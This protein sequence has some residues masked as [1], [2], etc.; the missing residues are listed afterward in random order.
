[1]SGPEHIGGDTHSPAPVDDTPPDPNQLTDES[2]QDIR[3]AAVLN[4][5][6]SLAV[7]MSGIT[8]ELHHL[9]LSSRGVDKWA[10]YGQVL[11]LL[12]GTVRIDVIAGT[13]AG[14]LNG[15]FLALG[16]TRQ[17]DLMLLRDLWRDS[18]ALEDLLR[19][20]LVKSPPSLLDGD[21]YF[22]PQIRQALK[23]IRD[24]PQ[25]LDEPSDDP[26]ELILTG[27]LWT[28]RETTFTDDMGVGITERDHDA[29]FRF[30][31]K[32][33]S[34]GASVC[35]DLRSDDVLDRLAEAARCTS[36]FPGAFEP[37]KVSVATEYGA[38]SGQR[39]ASSAG[40]SNFDT[41]QYVVDGGV[42]L[43]K[44][45]RPALGAIH[46]QTAD[47][48]VRRIL[49]YIVPDP[50]EAPK[51]ATGVSPATDSVPVASE[52]LLGVVTR[53]QATDS[54]SR[55][56]QE[57]RDRNTATRARRR[58]RSAL[59][60]AMMETPELAKALWPFYRA[61]RLR[62]AAITIGRLIAA[63]QPAGAGRWS[64]HEITAALTRHSAQLQQDYS[65]APPED[66]SVALS[67]TGDD[68]R[69]GQTTVLRLS[70]V[71]IDVLKRAVWLAPFGSDLQKAIVD[72]RANCAKLLA[73]IRADRDRLDTY[74][75]DAPRQQSIPP[76]TSAANQPATAADLDALDE[77]IGL[78]L[79]GWA[80]VPASTP[81]NGQT[82]AQT[83]SVPSGQPRITPLPAGTGAPRRSA[84]YGQA[85]A[86]AHQLVDRRS[87]IDAV[88]SNPNTAIDSDG[89]ERN[90]LQLLYDWL[91]KLPTAAGEF[92]AV[93]ALTA[94]DVLERMLRLDV[95]QLASTG[96]LDQVEQEVEL[97][98]ISCS[99]PSAITGMQLHHFGA[100]YRATWRVND[101]I[102]GRL[103]GTEQIMRI[104][105]SP[106]RLRQC[107]YTTDA[108]LAEL[109]K[110]AVPADPSHPYH[111]WLAD[112]WESKNKSYRTEVERVFNS[113]TEITA[114]TEVAAALA[115][116]LQLQI[117]AEDVDV[118][119]N[120]IKSEQDRNDIPGPSKEW[121]NAYD[122]KH[123]T[124]AEMSADELWKLRDGL[125]LIGAETIAND[126][127]TDIFARTIA[128]AATVTASTFSAPPKL[129]SVKA[130]RFVLSAVRGYTLMVWTMVHFMT[131][132]SSFGARA[133]DLA[134]AGGATLLAVTILVPGIPVGITLVGALLVLAGITTAAL[135]T[136]D[137]RGLV[138]RMTVVGLLVA[139]ALGFLI[140]DDIHV[141]GA[142]GVVA[143]TLI[144]VGVGVLIVL[145]GTFVA[146]AKSSTG[147]RLKLLG[148][149][150]ENAVAA[151]SSAAED[152]PRTPPDQTPKGQTP[153]Y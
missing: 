137:T 4:G 23:K 117:L 111:Q 44:P 13:S 122:A 37:H 66:M 146:G 64:A 86:L 76:R 136:K 6:V 140:W 145:I 32:A 96:A 131:M 5:G 53:L 52:V 56:L 7:W 134:V 133:I 123:K 35:G 139:A 57:I 116:P 92:E 9:T 59:S 120:A 75:T 90:Q 128:K 41:G 100:F 148:H 89:Y 87:D 31:N 152:P 68:W 109:R 33:M 129:T 150:G 8:L 34:A 88:L 91:L 99:T 126:A 72:S 80:T 10:P 114:L 93:P 101:W 102:Q 135:R 132:G 47:R 85:L 138:R 73:E 26:V 127:G 61:E 147:W 49:A 106:E 50:G 105:L 46:R 42:L 16:L 95:V 81:A 27:T 104:L 62:S 39:W 18:G 51:T 21:G 38:A 94:V 107:G 60:T 82:A 20:P 71:T 141:H 1:M 30:S 17:R 74:W 113:A 121:L 43:N 143:S 29:L 19:Q 115:R 84:M 110:I 22:L 28:G 63:G 2:K 153:T 55:E 70:D 97:V 15:A 103:D 83:I 45:I 130:V 67:Q 12:N 77:W 144:K 3:I 11:D 108:L 40:Q 48:Q 98:Q 149:R 118:L 151:G 36:S 69:W 79:P 142:S 125:I 78:V 25:L 14:G 112:Q 65:F 54:V 24:N 58:T 119:A 124:S